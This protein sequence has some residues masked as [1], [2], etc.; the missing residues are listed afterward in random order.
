MSY[1]MGRCVAVCVLLTTTCSWSWACGGYG[2]VNSVPPQLLA[3]F[4]ALTQVDQLTPAQESEITRVR[5]MLRGYG[6]NGLDAA[7]EHRKQR[8]LDLG[9]VKA[10]EVHRIDRQIDLIA[11]QK[12]AT[13]SQLFWH[14][15]REEAQRISKET[16][17][18]LLSLRMLGRLD[19]D[20]SCA[21]SRFFRTI[22]YPHDE[23]KDLLRHGF[24]LHWEPVRDVPIVTVDFGDGRTLRQPLVGNSVHLVLTPKGQV[25]DA[26]PGLVTPDSFRNW[27]AEVE[28]LLGD[29]RS[30]Q[31]DEMEVHIKH[32]HQRRALR[33]RSENSL[34]IKPNQS[35][36]D[37][38]PLDP[39]WNDAV[40]LANVQLAN[41][42][43]RLLNQ[44][45]PPANAAM[46]IAPMKS[47]A[48]AP[49]LRMVQPIEPRL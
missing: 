28:S 7:L 45:Q 47:A 43:R 20:L 19:E 11:A 16:G 23:I 22:L 10:A 5:E 15:S 38:N 31:V 34:A 24:V 25:V 2:E 33:R 17:R 21:N 39:R 8:I 13:Q 14:T 32:W 9:D 35:V 29:V 36:A 26:L 1:Q 27:L 37:L 6:Y 41:V 49:M 44:Q 46:R 40:N 30:G 42:T 3:K 18:P 48:E 4:A 12:F